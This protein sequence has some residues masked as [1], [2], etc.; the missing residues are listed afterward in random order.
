[1]LSLL[2][3]A[4][5]IP[6]LQG[7]DPFRDVVRAQHALFTVGVSSQSEVRPA[8]D[9]DGDGLQEL[10]VELEQVLLVRHGGDG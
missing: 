6:P 9:L 10:V 8:G 4:A 2:L 3:L 5:G 1:M 7:H